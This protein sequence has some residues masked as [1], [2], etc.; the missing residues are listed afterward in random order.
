MHARVSTFTGPPEQY[1]A[2]IAKFREAVVPQVQQIEGF[3]GVL[4]LV[5]RGSGKGYTITLW[6][7]EEALRASEEE[8]NKIREQA[9]A[10]SSAQ[11]TSVERYEVSLFEMP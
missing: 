5:D 9:A 6:E 1:D 4:G 8:A 10:A 3:R 2:G 11:I 7:S